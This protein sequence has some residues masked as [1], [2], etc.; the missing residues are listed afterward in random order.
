MS[1]EEYI[2]K[3]LLNEIEES[4]LKG[5]GIRHGAQVSFIIELV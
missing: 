3:S 4:L 2:K 5:A 1:Q